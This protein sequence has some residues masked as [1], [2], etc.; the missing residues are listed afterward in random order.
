MIERIEHEGP[1][2]VVEEFQLPDLTS[3]GWRILAVIQEQT[4][5]TCYDQVPD[6]SP[7][8]YSGATV[9][10]TRYY[11]ST[12]TRYLVGQTDDEALV[13]AIAAKNVAE[14]RVEENAKA[15][16]EAQKALET[17][18][19]EC[20]SHKNESARNSELYTGEVD[21]ARDL[22]VKL[23]KMEEDI[24]KLRTHFGEKTMQEVLAAE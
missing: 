6:P 18:E 21:R 12:S 9:S 19:A 11:P 3:N 2:K 4:T 23:R 1:T 7:Q 17:S 13:N 20:D 16:D 24:A 5:E 14:A 22:R 8:A 15:L 10:V